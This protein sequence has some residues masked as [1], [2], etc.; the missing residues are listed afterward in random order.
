[1]TLPDPQ[2]NAC[3]HSQLA[4]TSWFRNALEVVAPPDAD[5]GEVQEQRDRLKYSALFFK[6]ELSSMGFQLLQ[7]CQI[8]VSCRAPISSPHLHSGQA[9]LRSLRLCLSYGITL[10]TTLMA[11]HMCLSR[12]CWMHLAVMVCHEII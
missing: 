9:D 5:E 2:L 12:C 1:M 11:G 7:A 8:Q 6:G 3:A 10:P 4:A